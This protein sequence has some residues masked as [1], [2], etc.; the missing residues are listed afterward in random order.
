M[1]EIK[2]AGGVVKSDKWFLVYGRIY[3]GKGDVIQSSAYGNAE[4]FKAVAEREGIHYLG[5]FNSFEELNEAVN[6]FYGAEVKE[7]EPKD[8]SRWAVDS[9]AEGHEPEDVTGRRS[10]ITE[11]RD[12]ERHRER[13]YRDWGRS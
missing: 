4:A 3:K 7:D 5:E 8:E 12:L 11:T 13:R 2:L 10:E 9:E 1:K 6:K